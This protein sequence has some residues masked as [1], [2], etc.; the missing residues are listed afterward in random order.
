ML[1]DKPLCSFTECRK[2]FD[3]NCL[4]SGGRR[5]GCEFRLMEEAVDKAIK[6][7]TPAESDGS[8]AV[9][10]ARQVLLKFKA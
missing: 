7:L 8:R 3:H 4:A 5:E 1:I 10:R 9:E 6:M 2:N